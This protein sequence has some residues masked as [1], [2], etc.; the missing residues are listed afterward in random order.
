MTDYNII[1]IIVIAL[2]SIGII[3]IKIF[4]MKKNNKEV[5]I[6]SFIKEYSS[7]II[8]ILQDFI[9]IMQ[10]DIKNFDS[11][12]KY[13]EALVKLCV[14]SI[15]DDS[16]IF[17]IDKSIINIF[18]TDAIT[19]CVYKILN[20]HK[21]ECFSV[22]DPQV[23]SNNKEYFDDDVVE[24]ALAETEGGVIKDENDSTNGNP[25]ADSETVDTKVNEEINNKDETIEKSN[26]SSNE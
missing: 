26:T 21:T 17:G 14:E 1:A 25:S 4:S 2:A 11:K 19:E 6:N 24:A 13:N 5:T 16:S 7:N 22:L 9:K 8:K 12:E 3:A 18:N 10:V 20:A 23:I 15:K